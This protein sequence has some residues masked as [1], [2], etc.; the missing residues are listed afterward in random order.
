MKR[1]KALNISFTHTK[2]KHGVSAALIFHLQPPVKCKHRE[3]FAVFQT[4]FQQLAASVSRRDGQVDMNNLLK[5]FLRART[6][7]HWS[8]IPLTFL[9]LSFFVFSD[10]SSQNVQATQILR[11]L[12]NNQII[13]N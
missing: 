5:M 8:D 10:L 3:Q 11:V 6:N 2:K 1:K 7:F 12:S 9:N 13:H 4:K